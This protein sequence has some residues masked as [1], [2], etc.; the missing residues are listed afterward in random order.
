MNLRT[1]ERGGAVSAF[2]LMVATLF[3]ITTLA[4]GAISYRH[5]VTAGQQDA[6][7]DSWNNG[8]HDAADQCINML[9]GSGQ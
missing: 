8:F 4:V 3:L 1:S 6:A 7:H 5:G 2:G 9:K